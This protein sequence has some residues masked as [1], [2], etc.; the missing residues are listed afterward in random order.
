MQNI[1]IV[2][3]LNIHYLLHY[4]QRSYNANAGS[5]YYELS[6]KFLE[7]NKLASHMIVALRDGSSVPIVIYNP[8]AQR[9]Q[10]LFTIRTSSP[11][12]EVSWKP[13]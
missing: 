9:R 13:V 4:F 12:L 5:V 1:H 10:E 3:V 2:L 7:H 8:L 6:E 11:Y